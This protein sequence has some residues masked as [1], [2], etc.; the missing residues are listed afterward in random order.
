MP[1]RHG[2]IALYVARTST[3]KASRRAQRHLESGRDEYEMVAGRV[4]F[5][6]ETSTDVIVAITQKEA[7]PLARFAPNVPAEL[8]WII[9][10]ALRK[11]REERYQTIRELLT[12]LRRL[13]QKLEFEV[14]LERSVSPDSVSRSAITAVPAAP[15][16]QDSSPPLQ[17]YDSPS[18]KC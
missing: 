12:D 11:E 10:K 2:H 14:E 16:V 3:R 7:P 8:D 17:K 9:N 15:T 18:L 5:E 13:K 1:G 4:P 6:G